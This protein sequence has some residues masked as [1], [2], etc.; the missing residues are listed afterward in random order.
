MTVKP[1]K[2]TTEPSTDSSQAATS[3]ATSREHAALSACPGCSRTRVVLV[4]RRL[5][6]LDE[7]RQRRQDHAELAGGERGDQQPPSRVSRRSGP[8][9]LGHRR[10]APVGEQRPQPAHVGVA[11]GLEHDLALGAAAAGLHVHGVDAE[12][13]LHG[14]LL[15]VERLDPR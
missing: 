9:G 10:R 6:E 13:P 8:C 3:S 1:A 12:Q 11:D 4:E 14:P 15:E 5:H 7:A 2:A